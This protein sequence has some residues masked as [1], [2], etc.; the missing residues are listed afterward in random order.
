MNAEL[1]IAIWALGTV[2]VVLG[3]WLWRLW[4]QREK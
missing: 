4:R 1:F 3:R 2:G